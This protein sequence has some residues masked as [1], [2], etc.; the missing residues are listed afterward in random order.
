MGHSSHLSNQ[1]FVI[2]A[3]TIGLGWFTSV[4]FK[5]CPAGIVAMV[6]KVESPRPSLISETPSRPATDVSRYSTICISEQPRKT[7]LA[8]W[9]SQSHQTSGKLPRQS[10]DA[11]VQT[12]PPPD[13]D[14]LETSPKGAV[15]AVP[16]PPSHQERFH[17]NVLHERVGSAG[18]ADFFGRELTFEANSIS[19]WGLRK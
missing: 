14:T 9:L 3:L 13:S 1:L 10:S 16:H 2:W 5:D 12:S 17:M 15:P 8:S 6:K 11:Q 4:F 18:A 19:I 7:V